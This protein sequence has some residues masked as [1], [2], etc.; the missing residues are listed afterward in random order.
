MANEVKC[1]IVS[2]SP[3]N[4]LDFIKQN[5]GSEDYIIAA[6]SGYKKLE[7]FL[8]TALDQKFIHENCKDLYYYAKSAE[9]AASLRPEA[10]ST[11]RGNV[12]RQAYPPRSPREARRSGVRQP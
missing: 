6:D 4:D 7:A 9:D 1:V 10:A 3:E 8:D 12:P 2:G 5:I 11:P